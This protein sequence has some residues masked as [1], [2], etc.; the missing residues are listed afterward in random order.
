MLKAVLDTNLATLWSGWCC[1]GLSMALLHLLGLDGAVQL[2]LEVSSM[3]SPHL[4]PHGQCS[5]FVQSA[6]RSSQQTLHQ[7][8]LQPAWP[9][10]LA[11]LVS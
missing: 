3:K 8:L 10:H 1:Q 2:R 7:A 9:G 11:A 6:S 5:V 4:C